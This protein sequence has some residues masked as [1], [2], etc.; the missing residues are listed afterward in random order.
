MSL[1]FL[2]KDIR[3]SFNIDVTAR[4]GQEIPMVSLPLGGERTVKFLTDVEDQYFD[5]IDDPGKLQI[6]LLDVS[7][8][9]QGG[10][11]NPGTAKGSR[12]DLKRH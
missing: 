1:H 10:G 6:G 5:R 11:D 3:A 4:N 7:P 8:N 12:C 9:E 2:L